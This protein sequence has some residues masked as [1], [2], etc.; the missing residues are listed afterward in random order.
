MT[1]KAYIRTSM[2]ADGKT[3]QRQLC[4]EGNVICDLSFIEAIELAMQITSTL[5]HEEH[6][7]PPRKH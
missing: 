6:Y 1:Q 7:T 2:G 4:V 3:P 5:R